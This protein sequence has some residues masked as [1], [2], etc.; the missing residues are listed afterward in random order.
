MSR[1]HARSRPHP[2]ARPCRGLMKRVG[3]GW[4]AARSGGRGRRNAL[5]D[6]VKTRLRAEWAKL[7]EWN[8]GPGGISFAGATGLDL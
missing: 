2:A 4:G 7:G 8:G 5:G 6:E 1:P 3:G